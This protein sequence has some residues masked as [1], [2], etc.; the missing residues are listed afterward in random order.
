MDV[1]GAAQGATFDDL[2][3]I[4]RVPLKTYAKDPEMRTTCRK[5][6]KQMTRAG[7]I[8]C[9]GERYRLAPDLPD[10]LRAAFE[11]LTLARD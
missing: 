3:P 9:V 2:H 5:L 10:E 4:M 11:D 7:L 1:C 8:V 6:L